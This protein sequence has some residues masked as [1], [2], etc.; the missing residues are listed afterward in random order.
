MV[1][2]NAFRKIKGVSGLTGVIWRWQVRAINRLLSLVTLVIATGLRRF[3][4]YERHDGVFHP[5]GT[6]MNDT[7]AENLHSKLGLAVEALRLCDD[8]AKAGRLALEVMHDIR[9]P[10]E[11]LR[12][13][14][15]LTVLSAD[16][17][18]EVRRF[19]RLAEEQITI[20]TG[21]ANSVLGFAQAA[22]KPKP[23]NLVLSTEAALRIHQRAIEAK[24]VR[25][26]KELEEEVVAPVYT[27]EILQVISDLIHNVL[28]AL[29][30]DGIIRLRLREG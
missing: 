9:N 6:L 20:V 29:P 16:S 28:D 4:R 8:H 21:I 30:E 14:N 5:G 24:R 12:N 7:L 3:L 2:K 25:L 26:L 11:A 10:L 15:Y 17:P 23:V 27:S 19:A 22:N 18:T 1:A 13:L